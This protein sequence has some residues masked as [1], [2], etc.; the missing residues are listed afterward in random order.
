LSYSV[1]ILEDVLDQVLLLILNHQRPIIFAME[2]YEKKKKITQKSFREALTSITSAV[3]AFVSMAEELLSQNPPK[4]HNQ[5]SLGTI[6]DRLDWM[7]D[8]YS[9]ILEHTPNRFKSLVQEMKHYELVVN[10]LSCWLP[11]ENS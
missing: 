6:R 2:A 8:L 5:V 10:R 11:Q 7:K 4:V 1:T 3:D 9:K